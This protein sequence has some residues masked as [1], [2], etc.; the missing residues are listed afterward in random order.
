[1]EAGKKAIEIIIVRG[2]GGSQGDGEEPV[3]I[4][5]RFEDRVDRFPWLTELSVRKERRSG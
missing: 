4:W 1:M 5:T 3:Q 2:E